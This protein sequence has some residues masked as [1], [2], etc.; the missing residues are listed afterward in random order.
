MKLHAAT[1]TPQGDADTIG[2]RIDRQTRI[3]VWVILLGLANFLAYALGYMWIGGEAIHGRLRLQD[4]QTHYFLQSGKEVSR[5]VFI[6]S[7]VHSV[8]VWLTVAAIMLA[9][10]TIAKERIV[11]SMASSIV[12]GRW[13]ITVFAAVIGFA[14]AAMTVYFLLQFL[15]HFQDPPVVA[16]RT[17]RLWPI[18]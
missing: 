4:G 9:M 5:C 17:E 3:C 18:A 10:L 2:V 6:Y 7:G 13:L 16:L 12:R 11:S 8:S 14:T 1:E 15:Q